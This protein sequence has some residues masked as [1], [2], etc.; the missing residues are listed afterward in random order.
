VNGAQGHRRQGLGT[1]GLQLLYPNIFLP[2]TTQY[3]TI[4]VRPIAEVA[5]L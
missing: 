4:Y 1:P 3:D 5:S 2:D